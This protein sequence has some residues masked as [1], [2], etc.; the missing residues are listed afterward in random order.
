[1]IVFFGLVAVAGSYYL[2]SGQLPDDAV[3]LTGIAIGCY[4]A[5][6]LL[7]N[8]LRDTDADL[9]AGRKTLAIR[10]GTPTAQWLV[11][12]P[13]ARPLSDARG[14]VGPSGDRP[15]VARATRLPVAGGAVCAHAGGSGHERTARQN[16]SGPGSRRRLAHRGAALLNPVIST[17]LPAGLAFIMFALGLKLSVADF[18]R[19]SHLPGGRGPRAAGADGAAAAHGIRNHRV[20]RPRAGDRLSG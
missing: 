14:R 18:R 15:G 4:A 6:V 9:R 7:V 20:V 1:M 10:L 16:R 3:L 11:R 19:V 2:Q 12:L 13:V 8:N 17:L 5:A